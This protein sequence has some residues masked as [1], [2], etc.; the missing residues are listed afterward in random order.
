MPQITPKPG[1]C[2][3]T[4]P[5]RGEPL[6]IEFANTLHAVRGSLRDGI[7]SPQLLSWWLHSCRGR[8][9][10]ELPDS[11]LERIESAD[12]S[13]VVMLRD[14]TRRLIST[15]VHGGDPDPWDVAQ[16][17][18][19]CCMAQHW[20]LLQWGA[21]ERPTVLT[22]GVTRPIVAVQAE[23]ACAVVDLLS[24]VSG[25]DPRA[26]PAPGCV[27]FFDRARSRREW[28]SAGCGNRARAARHYARHHSRP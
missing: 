15:F 24:G 18:R 17:N 23:I 12:L 10:T 11:C 14:A 26:C 1:H 21:G 27:L 16:I 6:A 5:V 22:G 19:A 28:C 2:D 9:S 20:P 3:D 13:S 7:R 8:L 25:A 4:P